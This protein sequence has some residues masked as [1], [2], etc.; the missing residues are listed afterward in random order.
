M[1]NARPSRRGVLGSVGLIGVVALAG[2]LGG[3]SPTYEG[4]Q[5]DDVDGD[6]RTDAEMAAAEALAER[7]TQ[8]GVSPLDAVSIVEHEFV[9]EDDY[10]GSTVQGVVENT[11]S[12]RI[13]HVEVRVRAYDADGT[14][15]GRYLDRTG[16][17]D[18]G[19]RWNFTVIL[20]EAP[21]ALD[22][23]D[24]AVLGTPP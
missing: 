8:E 15:L 5:V 23:Y 13:E 17:I 16:D 7:E 24:V 19:D 21:D 14:H 3:R 22:S 9:L 1:T 6:E 18:G 4:G 11:G 10:L 20:L 12:E 2:C